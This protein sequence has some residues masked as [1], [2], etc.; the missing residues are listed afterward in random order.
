MDEA[1]A[2]EALD[3][4][5]GAIVVTHANCLTLLPGH[6][7]NRHLSDR[8]IRGLVERD[9]IIGVVPYNTFL[10]DSWLIGK[11]QRE[12]V[13]LEALVDH[14]DHICQLAGDARHVGVG[15]DF[16]GGFGLSSTPREIDTIE[17]LHKLVPMLQRRGYKEEETAGVLGANWI[18]HLTRSLPA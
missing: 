5:P 1:A 7:Y 14:I 10:K 12:E 15:S 9:G 6:E 18:D 11:S 13:S 2:L 17:D 3:I 8:Q 16:D 4:Y